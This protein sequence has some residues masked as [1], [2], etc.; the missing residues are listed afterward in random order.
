M[1][2]LLFVVNV[3]W[4]F[5]SHRLPIALAAIEEGYEVHLV[6]AITDKRTF[7]EGLGIQVHS[8]PLSRGVKG[9]L[10]DFAAIRK[11]SAV[12]N[13]VSPDVIHCITIKPVLYG[14][15]LSRIKNIQQLVYSISGLGFVFT[16]NTFSTR[17]LRALIKKIY[18]LAIYNSG[19]VIFQNEN[20]L[21]LLLD[22]SIIKPGQEVLIKGAGVEI[23]DYDYFPECLDSVP[24]VMFLARLLKDKG[25]FEFVDASHEVH[26]KYPDVRFVIVGDIDEGNPNSITSSELA[27]I[28][29]S[30][31]IDCWGYTNE[32][33]KIIPRANIMVLPSYREGFP[34]SLIEAAACG[35][36][37]VTTD[38]PGCRDAIIDGK[39]GLL[40]PVKDSKSLAR[41][42]ETLIDKPQYRMELGKQA[43]LLAEKNYRIQ[44]VIDVHMKLYSERV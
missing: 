41:A 18:K 14:G 10:G 42:I 16:D 20:D 21:K 24:I 44:D 43:R 8:Y 22:N 33:E 35:R 29:Q 13:Q 11:L 19:R 38:V 17:L 23:D 34:K 15:L 1:R 40:V 7:L 26:K 6:C 39:T 2:K 32:P 9:I 30:E 37:T 27:S 36:A 31:Y 5:V 4:F 3:D 25:I 28:S 12:I